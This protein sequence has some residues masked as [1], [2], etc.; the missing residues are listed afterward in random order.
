MKNI[1]LDCYEALSN[2]KRRSE[3]QMVEDRVILEKISRSDISEDP[4]RYLTSGE[5]EALEMHYKI[6]SFLR[7]SE[8]RIDRM[9]SCIRDF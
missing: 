9:I 1:T 4:D 7:T 2:L 3:F 6:A 5:K 8:F